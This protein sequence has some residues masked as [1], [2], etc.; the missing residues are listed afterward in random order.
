MREGG[1][2]GGTGSSLLLYAHLPSTGPNTEQVCNR[3]CPLNK[4]WGIYL[5]Y[6][7]LDPQNLLQGL[8]HGI[9]LTN[10]CLINAWLDEELDQKM[11]YRSHHLLGVG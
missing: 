9:C 1:R 3:Y 5:L 4:N 7:P 8:A 6:S 10:I 2:Q 11:S